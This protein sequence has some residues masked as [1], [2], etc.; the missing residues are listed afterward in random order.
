MHGQVGP[1]YFTKLTKS[2]YGT[3][4]LLFVFLLL[5]LFVF[6]VFLS[7]CHVDF[8]SFCLFAF[9]FFSFLGGGRGGVEG[10]GGGVGAEEDQEEGERRHV[11]VPI[12]S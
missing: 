10:E 6:F 1:A 7:F 4:S 5:Y 12:N 9:L 11:Q 8:L 3:L 2:Q